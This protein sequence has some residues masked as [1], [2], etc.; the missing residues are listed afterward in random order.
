VFAAMIA[1]QQAELS[2]MAPRFAE[3]PPPVEETQP[4]AAEKQA[5]LV[6]SVR[7]GNASLEVY[8][9]AGTEIVSALCKVLCHA[10]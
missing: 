3:L 2:D 8:S 1:Q 6:A 5:D 7:I 10:K 9:G 4:V